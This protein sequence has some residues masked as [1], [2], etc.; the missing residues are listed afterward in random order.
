MNLNKAM[1]VGRITNDLQLKTTES[2]REV[3]SFSVATNRNWKDQSGQKQERTDFHN[4]VAWANTAKTIA[5]YM[6]KGQ[7]IL[8]EGR[9]ETRD[10]EKEGQKHY[11]TEIVLD[12]FEFG[13][14]PQ[15][16]T[17]AP[18]AQPDAKMDASGGVVF[19]TEE[20]NPD[21]IPF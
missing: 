17:N 3:L 8:V 5:E 14:K 7:E 20:I 6:V 15:G 4:V 11:R 13:A 16:S 1:I 21:D 9:L 18:K 10:Y 19:P 2:G 12:R